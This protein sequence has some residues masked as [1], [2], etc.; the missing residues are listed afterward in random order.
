M[1]IGRWRECRHGE[2]DKTLKE[3]A[4]SK[5]SDFTVSSPRP[6]P[7]ILLADVSGNMA[8]NGKIETLNAAVSEMIA[9]FVEEEATRAEIQVAIITFGGSAARVHTPLKPASEVKWEN[10]AASGRTPMGSAFTT[11]QQIIEDRQLIPGRAY[12]PTIVLISDGI[13]TDDWK[14]PLELLLGSERASKAMRFAMGIGEEADLVTLKT[15]LAD[16]SSKVFHAHEAR[17]IKK[18]FRWLSMS[19]T[20]RSRSANPNNAVVVEPTDLDDFDF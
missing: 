9:T 16:P 15:F 7:V 11:V 6:L 12:R 14:T 3:E 20:S 8:E 18:F 2:R 10:M 17:E 19:V 5:L 13:P 4:M 1:G